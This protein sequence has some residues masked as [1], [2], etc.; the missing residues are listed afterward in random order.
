MI[1]FCWKSLKSE[2]DFVGSQK[3]SKWPKIAFYGIK[4]AL[5]VVEILNFQVAEI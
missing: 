4:K 5:I 2:G 3:G 1:S